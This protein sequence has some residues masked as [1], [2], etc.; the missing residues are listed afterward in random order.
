MK[1]LII[2]IILIFA[3]LQT[4][5]AQ[6]HTMYVTTIS[7]QNSGVELGINVFNSFGERCVESFNDLQYDVEQNIYTFIADASSLNINGEEYEVIGTQIA[8][9]TDDFFYIHE[10]GEWYAPGN[11][12]TATTNVNS[13]WT[14]G[15]SNRILGSQV[16]AL[17]AYGWTKD[18]AAL[19]RA[20]RGTH[21][22]S[23]VGTLPAG[24][25]F[26]YKDV[27]AST[28]EIFR[29]EARYFGGNLG[30]VIYQHRTHPTP[31]GGFIQIP[32]THL[33][34]LMNCAISRY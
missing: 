8:E 17:E 27:P 2:A 23:S 11:P 10:D 7:D 31:A 26:F 29:Y 5:Q 28:G 12:P 22:A 30:Y 6:R 19:D 33:N 18:Q 15:L 1:N 3:G 16:R 14:I 21:V 25:V 34:Q 24:D 4:M 9:L 13:R 32:T 20:R